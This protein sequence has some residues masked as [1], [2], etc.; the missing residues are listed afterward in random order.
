MPVSI[1]MA[2]EGEIPRNGTERDGTGDDDDDSV[3]LTRSGNKSPQ[4]L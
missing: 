4:V 1:G 2:A 3:G